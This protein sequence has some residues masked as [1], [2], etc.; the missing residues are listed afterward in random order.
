MKVYLEWAYEEKMPERAP[1]VIEIN[2]LQ[3]LLEIASSEDLIIERKG[4]IVVPFGE[5]ELEPDVEFGVLVY[6]GYIE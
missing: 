2:S 4:H 3:E 5:P 1:K 6:N